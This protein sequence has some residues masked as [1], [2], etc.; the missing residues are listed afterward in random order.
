G[1]KAPRT[2]VSVEAKIHGFDLAIYQASLYLIW[3]DYSY[4]AIPTAAVVSQERYDLLR[5]ERL[6]LMR[7]NGGRRPSVT[8][9]I[10]PRRSRQLLA[11]RKR[12]LIKVL[13]S[14][15]NGR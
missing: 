8:E 6:G 4:V 5:R 13:A 7:V 3:S 10:R 12:D 9:D 11:S 14:T 2:I 1:Y 15:K